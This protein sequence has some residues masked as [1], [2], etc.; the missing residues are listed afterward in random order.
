MLRIDVT[1]V[2]QHG[3]ITN[4]STTRFL[5]FKTVSEL[6]S[7]PAIVR[8]VNTRSLKQLESSIGPRPF[9]GGFMVGKVTSLPPPPPTLLLLL[10]LLV[11]LHYCY[12]CFG[13]TVQ[14]PVID[15][16]IF[17]PQIFWSKKIFLSCCS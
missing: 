15:P 10:L 16:Q 3:V 8:P 12:Y 2:C 4:K 5:T 1:L 6:T 7:A 11:L 9:H 14:F 17:L 13:I